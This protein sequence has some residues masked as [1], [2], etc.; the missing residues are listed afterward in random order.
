[1]HKALDFKLFNE[2]NIIKVT[3]WL[4]EK[5]KSLTQLSAYKLSQLNEHQHDCIFQH[6]HMYNKRQQII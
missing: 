4:T 3:V 6:W 2:S 5:T 1:M